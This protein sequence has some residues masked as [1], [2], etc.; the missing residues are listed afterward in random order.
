M[1]L[2]GE[3]V[4]LIR[5][6]LL[7][8]PVEIRRVRHVSMMEKQ[9][10]PVDLWIRKQMIDPPGRERGGPPDDPVHLIPPFQQL[11]SQVGAILPCYA[12]D[13][14]FFHSKKGFKDVPAT[15]P[16]GYINLVSAI[17]TRSKG[18]LYDEPVRPAPG[19]EPL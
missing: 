5:A 9:A 13:Q 8:Q 19:Q 3:V 11:L 10:N 7:Q 15:L 18:K 2:S 1:A 6:D 17:A 4:N 12:G 16:S 14:C